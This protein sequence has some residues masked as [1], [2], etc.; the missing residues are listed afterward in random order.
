MMV[1]VKIANCKHRMLPLAW[2]LDNNFIKINVIKLPGRQNGLLHYNLGLLCQTNDGDHGKRCL[3]L[4][5]TAILF[6]TSR[7]T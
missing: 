7:I 1:L 2:P 4:I 6:F 5:S 3:L